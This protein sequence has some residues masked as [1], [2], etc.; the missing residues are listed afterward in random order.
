M[1][2]SNDLDL[3]RVPSVAKEETNYNLVSRIIREDPTTKMEDAEEHDDPDII[4]LKSDP[5]DN[6]FIVSNDWGESTEGLLLDKLI[7][8]FVKDEE[9]DPSAYGTTT[10]LLDTED[11]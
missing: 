9:I 2:K 5:D 6:D 10:V 8:L 11:D 4:H 1:I 3:R 7:K